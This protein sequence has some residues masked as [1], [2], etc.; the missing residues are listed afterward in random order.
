MQRSHG[1][2]LFL[3]F[4]CVTLFMGLFSVSAFAQS[5]F[6]P[7]LPTATNASFDVSLT[8]TLLTMP[9]NAFFVNNDV[10]LD[11]VRWIDGG[12]F[13]VSS[14]CSG[15][16]NSKGLWVFKEDGT[17]VGRRN[18][19]LDAGENA[20]ASAAHTWGVVSNVQPVGS[21]Q[22][23][24]EMAPNNDRPPLLYQIS[25][26]GVSLVSRAW[27]APGLG[28]RNGNGLGA[29]GSIAAVPGYA[30]A[31]ENGGSNVLYS[32][33][34]WA[35]IMRNTASFI[36]ITGAGSFIVGVPTPAYGGLVLYRVVNGHL[37]LVNSVSTPIRPV[38]AAVDPLSNGTRVGFLFINDGTNG[39]NHV[40]IYTLGTNGLVFEKKIDLPSTT[41]FASTGWQGDLAI[42]GEYTAF[43]DCGLP[44]IPTPPNNAQDFFSV[45]NCGLAVMKGATR[46]NVERLPYATTIGGSSS[47][48]P[49][50]TIPP[51]LNGIA[52]SPNGTVVVTSFYG[53]YMYKILGA[54]SQ[55]GTPEDVVATT[56]LS[57]VDDLPSIMSAITLY[58]KLLNDVIRANPF[59][60]SAGKKDPQASLKE[61]FNGLNDLSKRLGGGGISTGSVKTG[62]GAS[63][64]DDTPSY[65]RYDTVY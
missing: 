15:G 43:L 49:M 54:A 26:S 60:T 56:D 61:I 42:S 19:C 24:K 14:Y 63:L 48:Q 36:P 64:D 2:R 33:P 57:D 4:L 39:N 62:G 55:S 16:N 13:V 30:I 28:G 65:S 32:L 7:P 23:V 8:K 38:A 1:I 44:P 3:G 58:V 11:G 46:L 31:F 12:Y 53:A 17:E 20:S 59:D 35:V 5:V 37:Q 29:G 52:L 27:P 18:T 51:G 41:T 10:P 47:N 50:Q 25:G 6:V 9:G 45:A 22:F 34:G 40:D 21:G